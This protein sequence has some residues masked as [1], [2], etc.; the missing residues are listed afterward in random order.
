MRLAFVAEQGAGLLTRVPPAKNQ[1]LVSSKDV[2]TRPRLDRHRSTHIIVA[3]V[4][5]C[6]RSRTCASAEA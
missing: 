1:P 3:S 5:A 2:L 4:R 6:S